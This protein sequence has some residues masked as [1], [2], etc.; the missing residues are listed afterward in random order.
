[1]WNRLALLLLIA[2]NIT[3]C[4]STVRTNVTVFQRLPSVVSTQQDPSLKTYTFKKTS[5]QAKSLEYEEYERLIMAELGPLGLSPAAEDKRA[6]I[7][8]EFSTKTSETV[9]TYIDYQ[10]PGPWGRYGHYSY[11]YA[12]RGY[13]GG[14]FYSGPW[15]P[16]ERKIKLNRHE[17]KVQLF[18][19]TA[20]NAGT[21]EKPIWEG[22]VFTDTN[23]L[24]L[25]QTMP[26]LAQAL[27]KNYPGVNGQSVVIDLPAKEL[28]I[29]TVK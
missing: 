23:I 17:L 20:A 28:P 27:F 15:F 4:A 24:T 26:Y 8:V 7:S 29:N 5:E 6:D 19:N 21:R 22:T 11:G 16:V 9:N 18:D 13:L 25:P 2:L 3:G 1:M 10:P 14:R 12:G